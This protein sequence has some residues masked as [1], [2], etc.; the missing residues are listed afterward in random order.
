MTKN[1]QMQWLQRGASFLLWAVVG[2]LCWLAAG[3]HADVKHNSSRID[4]NKGRS[5]IES[6]L[7][8]EVRDDVKKLLERVPPKKGE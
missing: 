3:L 1:E 8:Q 7:L 4:E 6:R 5:D 2:L